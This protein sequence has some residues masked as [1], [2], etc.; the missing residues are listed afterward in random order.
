MGAC[1]YASVHVWMVEEST[2]GHTAAAQDSACTEGWRVQAPPAAWLTPTDRTHLTQPHPRT[3]TPCAPIAYPSRAS[4]GGSTDCFTRPSLYRTRQRPSTAKGSDSP[5][6]KNHNT[7]RTLPCGVRDVGVRGEGGQCM[8]RRCK[9]ASNLQG[10][11]C[12]DPLVWQTRATIALPR[13]H[14][15]CIAHGTTADG[16]YSSACPLGRSGHCY[17]VVTRPSSGPI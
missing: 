3:L 14:C 2:H 11:C 17:M 15:C 7:S 6:S 10:G 16:L 4:D 1:M 5:G 8:G 9:A 13:S 12:W